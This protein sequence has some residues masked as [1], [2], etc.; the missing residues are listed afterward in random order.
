M[1][2]KYDNI[3]EKPKMV[4]MPRWEYRDLIRSD[5]MLAVVEKL[6]NNLDQY[7]AYDAIKCLLDD[8]EGEDA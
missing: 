3:I 7:K 8:G 5:A 1:S 2:K 6:V 4:E